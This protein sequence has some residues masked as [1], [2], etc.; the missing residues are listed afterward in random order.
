M[1]ASYRSRLLLGLC[2]LLPACQASPVEWLDGAAVATNQPSPLE[3]AP[4]TPVDTSLHGS[5]PMA[6]FFVTQDL[7]RES[8]ATTL[9]SVHLDSMPESREVAVGTTQSEA[10]PHNMEHGESGDMGSD[11]RPRDDMRCVRSLRVASMPG[12]GTVAVWWSRRDGG[13]VALLSAWRD[14]TAAGLGPWHGPIAIDTSDQGPQD[15]RAAERGAVGCDRPAPHVAFDARNGFIHVVY[16]VARPEGSGI[17]YAHQ[18][19]RHVPFEPPQVVLYGDRIGATRVASDGDIVV[20][21]YEDPNSSATRVAIGLAVSR[22]AGH[23]FDD[24]LSVSSSVRGGLDP[25]VAVKGR[26]IVVGW[27]EYQGNNTKPEFLIRRARLRQ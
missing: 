16:S 25:H 20:V 7:L 8:G 13:R 23:I 17:F 19:T 10:I 12:N 15:A 14:S 24:R 3:A 21:A 6:D 5:D 18:M 4:S 22:S 1:S 2:L 26:A 27:T 9:L 11:V